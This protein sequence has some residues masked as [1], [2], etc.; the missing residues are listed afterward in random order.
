MPFRHIAAAIVLAC[1]LQACGGIT[2]PSKNQVVPFSGVFEVGGAGPVH[3]FSASKNGEFFVTLTALAPDTTAIVAIT[4]GQRLS[5]G[6]SLLSTQYANVGRQAFTGPL[7][8]GNYCL[9]VADSGLAVLS[10]PQTY[11]L[12]VS[13]P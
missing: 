5:G 6:C 8:K 11:N 9:Q 12:R 2:D 4:L 1:A 3:D 7:D 10:G 13:A